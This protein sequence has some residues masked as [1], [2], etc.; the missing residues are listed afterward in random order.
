MVEFHTPFGKNTS[1]CQRGFAPVLLPYYSI[2]KRNYFYFVRL[3]VADLLFSSMLL[4]LIE[5]SLKYLRQ[6]DICINW[7]DWWLNHVLL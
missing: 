1:E 5:F 3:L 2:I 4:A 6:E 7:R